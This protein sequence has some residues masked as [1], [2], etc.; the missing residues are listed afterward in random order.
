MSSLKKVP[1]ISNEEITLETDPAI[2][3]ASCAIMPKSHCDETVATTTPFVVLSRT[4]R[5]AHF[6]D[7]RGYTVKPL[8]R[9]TRRRAVKKR[10]HFRRNSGNGCQRLVLAPGIAESKIHMMSKKKSRRNKVPS[11]MRQESRKQIHI[12]EKEHE[13]GP[14]YHISLRKVLHVYKA[15]QKGRTFHASKRIIWR[16]RHRLFLGCNTFHKGSK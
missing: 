3:G 5:R 1:S 13:G 14:V 15:M 8:P 9:I 7:N 11:L 16:N 4:Q 2:Y 12:P 6:C 10:T